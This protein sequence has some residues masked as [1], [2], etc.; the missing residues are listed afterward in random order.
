MGRASDDSAVRLLDPTT[1]ECLQ[2]E[3]ISK[4][5]TLLFPKDDQCLSTDRRHIRILRA[6][7]PSTSCHQ[8]GLEPS[9]RKET[10]VTQHD[11]N[12]HQKYRAAQLLTNNKLMAD[13]VTY[14]SRHLHAAF[15]TH[16]PLLSPQ[17]S[18][19]STKV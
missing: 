10:W 18:M 12:F 9:P 3:G 16:V 14:F 11:Q 2:T 17:F 15:G 8:Q 7:L 6:N 13:K 4:L 19:S 1:G 5:S